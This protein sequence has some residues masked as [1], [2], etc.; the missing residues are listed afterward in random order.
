MFGVYGLIARWVLLKHK[1]VCYLK[2]HSKSL[3]DVN[4]YQGG[5]TLI[6][7]RIGLGRIRQMVI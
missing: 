2:E 7:D 6:K 1:C 4:I 5:V 3:E